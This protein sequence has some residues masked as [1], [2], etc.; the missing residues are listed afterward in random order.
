MLENVKVCAYIDQTHFTHRH[1]CHRTVQFDTLRPH[2]S[3]TAKARCGPPNNAVRCV[4]FFYVYVWGG[5]APCC[6]TFRAGA[7]ALGLVS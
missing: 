5:V 7:W 1:M 4:A 2:V 3:E 6:S